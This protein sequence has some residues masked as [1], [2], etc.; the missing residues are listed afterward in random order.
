M[1]PEG[2]AAISD[3]SL[4]SNSAVDQV[5]GRGREK[6]LCFLIRNGQGAAVYLHSAS[7]VTIT[8]T[9]FANYS[10]GDAVI[11]IEEDGTSSDGGIPLRLL[12]GVSFHHLSIPAVSG[13]RI[14]VANCFGFSRAD[15]ETITVAVCADASSICLRQNCEDDVAEVGVAC[16]CNSAGA[17]QSATACASSAQMDV[18]IPTSRMSTFVLEKPDNATN[19]LAL[20]NGGP[21][22]LEWNARAAAQHDAVWQLLPDH[23][24]VGATSTQVVSVTAFSA[25]LQARSEPHPFNFTFIAENTCACDDQRAIT[26]QGLVFISASLDPARSNVTVTKANQVVAGGDVRFTVTPVRARA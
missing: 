13:S 24:S 8:A 5:R 25:H 21:K 7:T 12:E 22:A 3:S 1:E 17:R 15:F 23:S 16:F 26:M 18:Y 6:Y 20:V 10:E 11:H 9:S 19:E 4:Y 2:S 14:A